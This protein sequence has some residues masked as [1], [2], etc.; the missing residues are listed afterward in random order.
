MSLLLLLPPPFNASPTAPNDQNVPVIFNSTTNVI[1]PHCYI[2]DGQDTPGI[3]PTNLKGCQDALAVLVRTPDFTTRF[4]FSKNPR[5]M[6]KEVPVGW[7]LSHE[8]ECRIVVNCENDRDTAVFRFADV[9]RIAKLIMDNCVGKPDPSGR[10]PLLKWGGVHG[11]AEEET[12]YVAVGRP[13]SA[14]EFK[15]SNQTVVTSGGLVDG[16]VESA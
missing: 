7:Q 16:G 1:V 13:Q 15:V 9:A 5:A 4:R 12:F 11:I 14:L 2:P 8:S 10:Y 3:R 6:A